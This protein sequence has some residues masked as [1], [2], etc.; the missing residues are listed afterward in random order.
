MNLNERVSQVLQK[1]ETKR[2]QRAVLTGTGSDFTPSDVKGEIFKLMQLM[3]EL[4]RA[5]R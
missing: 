4:K 5:V 1:E 2:K 3:P